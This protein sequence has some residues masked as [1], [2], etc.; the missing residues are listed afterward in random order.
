MTM[1]IKG[2]TSAYGLDSE[3][4]SVLGDLVEVRNAVSGRNELLDL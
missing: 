3:A 1:D 4:A 2:I